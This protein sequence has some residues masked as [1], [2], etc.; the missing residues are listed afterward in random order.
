MRSS[1]PLPAVVASRARSATYFRP[2]FC[3]GILGAVARYLVDGA[4]QDRTSGFFPFGTLTVNISGSLMF[5]VLAGICFTV[6][7]LV[8]SLTVAGLELLL[9]LH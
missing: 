1:L 2:F 8:A 9:V 5:G 7:N 4:V 6:A 3:V